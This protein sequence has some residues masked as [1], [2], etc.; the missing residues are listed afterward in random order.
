MPVVSPSGALSKE[1]RLEVLGWF[2]VRYETQ[3]VFNACAVLA[4]LSD[5]I[6]RHPRAGHQAK[7]AAWCYPGQTKFD[8]VFEMPDQVRQPAS[9]AFNAK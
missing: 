1:A 8:E 4:R 5:M 6:A 9:P 2:L 7:E 3:G